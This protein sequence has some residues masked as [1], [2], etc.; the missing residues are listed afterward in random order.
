MIVV[1]GVLLAILCIIILFGIYQKKT[2]ALCES[3]KRIDGKTVLVTGGTAGMGLEIARELA[4][5]GA[6]VIVACPFPEEG[7]AAREHIVHTTGNNNVQFKHLDLASLAS[8]RRFADEVLR[9]ENRLDIL[10]NNAGVAGPCER[11]TADG[12][13]IVM[14]V[15]YFGTFLLTLLLL[16]LLKK[17]GMPGERSRIVNTASVLHRLGKVSDDLNANYKVLR[18]EVYARSKLCV[19]LF[20]REL[21]QRLKG[22]NVVVNSV[23]PGAV[24]TGIFQS[25]NET[26]GRIVRWITYCF[27]KTPWEGAQTALHVALDEGAGDVT[28]EFFRNCRLSSASQTACDAELAKTLWKESEKLVKM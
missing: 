28:G 9:N 3:K 1:L 26:V 6:R 23:D 11:N 10:V 4:T 12:M 21:A 13:N 17:T 20:T 18:G 8:T 5:R 16:P 2:N 27:F 19:V 14:Q 22:E 24:G 25:W 15:N 7:I